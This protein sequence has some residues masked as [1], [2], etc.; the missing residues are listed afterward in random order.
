MRI[1]IAK[2]LKSGLKITFKY[3]L[4]GV[5]QVLE[6]EGEWKAEAVEIMKTRFPSS[7]EKMLQ[8]IKGQRLDTPW[9]F[10][11]ITDVSFDAFIKKYPKRVGRKEVNLKAWNKLSEGDMLEAI[12]Y[13]PELIKLKADGTAFPYPAT[14]LNQKLWR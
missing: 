14:Y 10:A 4:N 9:I 3:N 13:I 5:L 1:F 11:E 7:T 12:L 6:F 2:H 8:E